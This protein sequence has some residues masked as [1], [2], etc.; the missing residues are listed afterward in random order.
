MVKWTFASRTERISCGGMWLLIAFLLIAGALFSSC[1]SVSLMS[2]PAY[3]VSGLVA[4]QKSNGYV[5]KIE[6]SKPIGKVAAWIGQD[7]WL[8]ITIPDTSVDFSKLNE[9]KKSSLVR[10]THF[11]RY[12]SSVQVTLQLNGEFH[13]LQVLRY[14]EDKNIYIVLYQSN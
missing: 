14:P 2:V 4:E 6:A 9:L 12:E 5:L 11:F 10:N 3:D 8:Y 7:N 13:D 1:S